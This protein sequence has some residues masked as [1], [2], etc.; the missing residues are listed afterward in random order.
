MIFNGI[1]NEI[2][3]GSSRISNRKFI[4]QIINVRIINGQNQINEIIQ[5]QKS[6]IETVRRDNC[7]LTK[8]LTQ[9]GLGYV[10]TK[11]NTDKA[12]EYIIS[13]LLQNT[14]DLSSLIIT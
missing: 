14:I 12:V 4:Y 8:N 2:W 5:T 6:C 1:S 13:K 10:L 7:K 3:F 11:S 9:S